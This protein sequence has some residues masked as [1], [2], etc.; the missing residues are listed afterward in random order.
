MFL[1]KDNNKS[2]IEIIDIIIVYRKQVICKYLL[3][4]NYN[5]YMFSKKT[6]CEI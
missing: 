1:L 2:Q 4:L 6:Y 3:V 5:N